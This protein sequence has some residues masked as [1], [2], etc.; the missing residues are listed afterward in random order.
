MIDFK[1]V[2]FLCKFRRK[3]MI[4]ENVIRKCMKPDRIPSGESWGVCDQEHCPYYGIEGSHVK[5]YDIATG[6]EVAQLEN[7]RFVLDQK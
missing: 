4:G 5:V 3:D 7:V 2:A 1:T 6:N